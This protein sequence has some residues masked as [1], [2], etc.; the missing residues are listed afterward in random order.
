MTFSLDSDDSVHELLKPE[1]S[2]DRKKRILMWIG[3]FVFV[4]SVIAGWRLLAVRGRSSIQYKTMETRQGNLNV[5][6]TATG[7]LKPVNQVDVG[8]EVSGTIKN[9]DVDYNDRVVSGQ[10]LATLDTTKLEAQV[11]QSEAA[12]KSSEASLLQARATVFEADATLKR[13]KN[14]R[15]LS[16]GKL[17]SLY[18]MDVAEATLKRAL[19]QEASAQAQIVQSRAVLEAHRSDLDKGVIRAPISGIV[20]KRSVEPGQTVAASLQTPVLFTLAEDLTVMELHVGVDEADIGNV[21]E[22]QNAIFTVDAYPDRSFPAKITQVRYASETE[23]GVVTYETLLSV[24]NKGML[25]RPGMTATADIRVME[26]TNATLAPNA[27]FRFT[28]P[29]TEKKPAQS[30]GLVGSLFVRPPRSG[31]QPPAPK[32]KS[33]QVWF[34]EKDILKPIPVTTGATDGTWTQILSGKI[35]PG[36]NLVVDQAA[37]EK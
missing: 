20:L 24:D 25:L 4:L 28:P 9:V 3:V 21:R 14:A 18:E 6:V 15:E 31:M 32:G 36:M 29:S 1:K 7:E 33:I 5:T 26:I 12:L 2:T 34:L 10:V 13:F 17:P 16:K 22:G 27:A 19:A 23:N 11:L 8:I 30:G 35:T 37:V